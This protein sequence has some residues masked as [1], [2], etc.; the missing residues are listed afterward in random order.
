M[1][2]QQIKANAP[3]GAT[4]YAPIGILGIVYLKREGD[5]LFMFDERYKEWSEMLRKFDECYVK[6]LP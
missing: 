2:L 5:I 6:P 3:D 1:T 4:H